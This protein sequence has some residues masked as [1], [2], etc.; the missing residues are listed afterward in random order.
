M[1]ETPMAAGGSPTRAQEGFRALVR[2]VGAVDPSG[3]CRFLLW[4]SVEFDRAHSRFGLDLV[5]PTKEIPV[6]KGFRSTE[7]FYNNVDLS[8]FYVG[9]R[10][11]L[12]EL[13]AQNS[14]FRNYERSIM[15]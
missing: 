4:I 10:V 12:G 7:C 3:C 6:I 15:T 14:S 5:G 11:A 1:D 8:L 2:R 13:T 9:I